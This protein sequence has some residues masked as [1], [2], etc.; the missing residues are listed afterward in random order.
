MKIVM[1]DPW[2]GPKNQVKEIL[3]QVEEMKEDQFDKNKL[4]P[5]EHE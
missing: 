4:F 1:R 3:S 2:V 5:N